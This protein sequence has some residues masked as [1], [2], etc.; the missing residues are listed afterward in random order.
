MLMAAMGEIQPHHIHPC[1]ENI[2]IINVINSYIIERLIH[3][4]PAKRSFLTIS[5]L[6]VA[7]PTVHMIPVLRSTFFLMSGF[8]LALCCMDEM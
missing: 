4:L 6:S 2:D 7:G 5:G 8:I 1:K 3:G